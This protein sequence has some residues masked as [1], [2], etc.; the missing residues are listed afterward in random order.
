MIYARPGDQFVATLEGAATGMAGTIGVRI[1]NTDGTNQ[2]PRTT[3]GIV[4]IEPDSGVYTVTLTAPTTRGKYIVLWDDGAPT[5]EYAPEELTVTSTLPEDWEGLSP[6]AV[7]D[8]RDVRVLIPRM[9]RALDG[10]TATSSAAVSS[11]L[12]DSE[13]TNVIADAIAS[14]IFYSG[15][16][17]GKTLEVTERDGYYLSPVSWRTSE[18]LTEPE[19]TVIVAQAAI[20]Y[21]HN[22][23]VTMKTQERIADEGQEWS[24]SISASAVSER[25]KAL[26]KARDEA[27][28][29]LSAG[30]GENEAWESFIAVRDSQVSALI[31]PWVGGGGQ[32]GQTYDPR[33][34]TPF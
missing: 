34:G 18:E 11:T 1:E 17:W 27:I 31:E 14:V 30:S 29:L 8:P 3:S 21:W 9:R 33:F 24:Y 7:T 28:A 23:L 26:Q 20:D 13:L 25:I 15:S 4:E 32:G 22:E 10:P 2:T 19:G 5:P 12:N 6:E 16:A